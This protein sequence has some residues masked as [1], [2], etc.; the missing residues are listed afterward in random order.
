MLGSGALLASLLL[1]RTPS[2]PRRRCDPSAWND[3]AYWAFADRLQDHLDALLGRRACTR[4]A[5]SMLNANMLLT[6]AAAALAGHTGPGAPATTARASS[7]TALCDGPAWVKSPPTARRATCPGW[8]DALDGRRHPAPGGRHRDRLGAAAIAWRAREALGLDQ[9]TADLIADRIIRTTA[10][11]FWRWPALRLNQI[12]WYARMYAGGRGGRRDRG[13]PARAA[14][15]ASCSRFVDGATRADGRRDGL[16]PR[17]GLPLPLPPGR[18]RRHKYNLDTAEYANIVCGFLVAYQ[19]ARDAGMPALDSARARV[20]RAWCERVLCGYWTHAGYLNWDTGLGFKRWHQGKKLGLS[21]GRAARDRD[22]PGARRAHGAWAKH[23]LDRSFELFDRWTERGRGLPPANAF[24]V[25]VDRRQRVLGAARRRARAG[26]RRP[27]RALRARARCAAR[28]RR[29][30]TPTTPTSAASRS[31]RP[32]TTRRSSPSTAARS[33]T[34]GSSSRGCSTA[35]RTSRAASAG[36]RRRRSASSCAT[37]S[38]DRRTPRSARWRRR[39]TTPLQLLEAPRGATAN[40]QTIRTARTRARSRPCA[41]RARRR[42]AGSRSARRT[43]F[44]ATYIETEWR[45]TGAEGKQIE[46]LFPSW[47]KGA[48]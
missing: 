43:R 8:R 41:C 6:H 4:P 36:A 47:G 34:A 23:M 3:A 17:P 9:A 22:V 14:A 48:R 21:P 32:P 31:P 42:A 33:R 46:V 28:S 39:A 37:A 11:E 30:C 7:S 19:Q 12:N 29:R 26:Q 5:R 24:D 16:Q 27:G 45:V 38:G 2:R 15:E 20:V 35:S 40:P 10:G 1:P 13:R 25:P 44:K 18:P